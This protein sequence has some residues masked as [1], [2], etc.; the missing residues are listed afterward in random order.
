MKPGD[1]AEK[2]RT[3]IKEITKS[4]QNS[5]ATLL[6]HQQFA[7]E[8]DKLIKETLDFAYDQGYKNGSDDIRKNNEV[9]T[10]KNFEQYLSQAGSNSYNSMRLK[11]INSHN[12]YSIRYKSFSDSNDEI[13]RIDLKEKKRYL[14]FR[15]L[16]AIGIAGVVLGTAFIANKYGIP[17]PL[18]GVRQVAAG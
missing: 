10:P 8:M 7:K 14:V 13:L 4:F 17:L 11:L 5:M 9:V 2:L 3:E 1:A 16:T 18:S 15:I 6:S 12:I